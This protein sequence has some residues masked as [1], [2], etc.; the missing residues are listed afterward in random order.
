M[1]NEGFTPGKGAERKA[2]QESTP[3]ESGVFERYVDLRLSAYDALM[4]AEERKNFEQE[5]IDVVRILNEGT[6]I[7][8]TVREDLLQQ[9]HTIEQ[10]YIHIKKAADAVKELEKES[11]GEYLVPHLYENSIKLIREALDTGV[12]NSSLE[13]LKDVVQDYLQRVQR[14]QS[15]Q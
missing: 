13:P 3:Q 10:D 6:G 8:P 11:R 15:S 5:L 7:D 4:S 14:L 1:K 9:I 12:P 2:V